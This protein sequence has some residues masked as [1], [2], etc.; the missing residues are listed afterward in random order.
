MDLALIAL[1]QM[2]S[3]FSANCRKQQFKFNGSGRNG[4]AS[5]IQVL[6]IKMYGSSWSANDLLSAV[7]RLVW[8]RRSMFKGSF[9]VVPARILVSGSSCWTVQVL[10]FRYN[11]FT[12]KSSSPILNI[13]YKRHGSSS[14]L[15]R[16]GRDL[17]VQTMLQVPNLISNMG[18]SR[19]L[20]FNGVRWTV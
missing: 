15:M 11:R 4:P 8:R 1:V 13:R 16:N 14:R 2:P 18:A 10:R 20:Q 5:E 12:L 17:T 9:H 6:R 3:N 19:W 7:E